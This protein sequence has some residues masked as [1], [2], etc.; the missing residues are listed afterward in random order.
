M[1]SFGQ[2]LYGTYIPLFFFYFIYNLIVK[3]F[4]LRNEVFG[5]FFLIQFGHFCLQIVTFSLL[6]F[7]LVV[8][9][10]E[11]TYTILFFVLLYSCTSL[12]CCLLSPL[13]GHYLKLF[14]FLNCLLQ[15]LQYTLCNVSVCLKVVYPLTCSRIH[16]TMISSLTSSHMLSPP[17]YISKIFN[18]FMFIPFCLVYYLLNISELN[19]MTLLYLPLFSS[20]FQLAFFIY[21]EPHFHLI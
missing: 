16:Y 9:M 21:V 13:V 6:T 5:F 20:N 15:V 11:I 1:V 12:F 18:C 19:E 8:N 17:H 7:N 3:K 14:F 2:Y 4:S 10:I